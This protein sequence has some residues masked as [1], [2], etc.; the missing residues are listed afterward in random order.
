[1]SM[2]VILRD[3][4]PAEGGRGLAVGVCEVSSARSPGLDGSRG[5]LSSRP[6]GE[7]TTSIGAESARGRVERVKVCLV[8]VVREDTLV[9][10]LAT[11]VL[12]ALLARGVCGDI[13][14]EPAGRVS[15][16]VEARIRSRRPSS[17]SFVVPGVISASSEG[18]PCMPGLFLAV[19]VTVADVA[20]DE[21]PRAGVGR[22]DRPCTCIPG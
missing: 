18:R 11:G 7:E 16:M 5:N 2:L 6:E 10:A 21:S 9:S 12:V 1:M 14:N 19:G 8:G 15:S 17:P 22:S 3:L 20:T 13:P 4:T